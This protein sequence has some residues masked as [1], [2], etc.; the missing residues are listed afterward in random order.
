MNSLA[1]FFSANRPYTEVLPWLKRL[2]S[3]A[4]LRVLQTF[5]LHLTARLNL[6][7]CPCPHHG[8]DKCDCQM[9]VLLIYGKEQQPVT[10]IL[11][12]NQRQTWLSL[13]DRPDQ[14]A[15]SSI[16]MSIEKALQ[17]NPSKEGL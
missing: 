16:R 7:P 12:G 8:T 5:D 4:G 14:R 11:H 2:L 10:L 3:R 15:A 17:V 13:I 1:P 9:I 6:A